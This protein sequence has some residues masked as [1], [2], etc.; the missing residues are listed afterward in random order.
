MSKMREKS[1]AT[2]AGFWGQNE[3]ESQTYQLLAVTS[4]L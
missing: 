2:R 3:L 4:N 1:L